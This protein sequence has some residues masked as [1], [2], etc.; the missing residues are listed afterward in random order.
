M[1]VMVALCL[2]ERVSFTAINLWTLLRKL[3]NDLLEDVEKVVSRELGG[4]QGDCS[5]GTGVHIDG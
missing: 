1:R 2:L 3:G 4:S 5:G